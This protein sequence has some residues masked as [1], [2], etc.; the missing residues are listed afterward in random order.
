MGQS[1]KL[2]FS[3]N[4]PAM[5]YL[6]HDN[7]QK[8]VPYL[9]EDAVVSNAEPKKISPFA[10]QGPNSGRASVIFKGLYF[11]TY[12]LLDRPRKGEQLFPGSGEDFNGVGSHLQPKFLF[13]P[14]P[15]NAFFVL[16]IG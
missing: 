3:I 6:Y 10:L 16:R 1:L 4:L 7:K 13:D 5:S 9:I 12:A 2:N 14:I 11:L 15:R 8:F